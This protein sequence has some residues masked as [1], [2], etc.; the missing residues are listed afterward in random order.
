MGRK[1][2]STAGHIAVIGLGPGSAAQA[3]PEASAAVAAAK[4]FYG[5]GP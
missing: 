3:T 5:Y 2:M 4:W 1:T